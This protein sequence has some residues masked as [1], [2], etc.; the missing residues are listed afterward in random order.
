MQFTPQQLSG[1]AKYSS[2]T[3]VGNWQEEIALEES[4]RENFFYKSS[5][6]NLALRKQEMK[7]SRC[8]EIVSHSYNAD[9]IVRFGDSVVLFHDF[10]GSCLACDPYEDLFQGQEKYLVTGLLDAPLPRARCTFRVERPPQHLRN[11]E[12]DPNDLTLKIGQ[13][14]CLVCNESLL[15]DSN[16]SI[17][18]PSLFL[19][20]TKKNERMATKITNRQL[21]YMTPRCD[22]EAIWTLAKPSLGRLNASERYLSIGSPVTASDVVELVHRQTNMLLSCDPRQKFQTEF[23]VEMECYADRVSTCGK[24]GLLVSEFNG[25]STAHTLSKPDAQVFGWHFVL[26]DNPRSATTSHAL[27]SRATFDNVLRQVQEFILS[28]GV[29]GFWQLRE[30]FFQLEKRT[31]SQGKFDRE[32][33]KDALHAFGIPSSNQYLDM[34]IDR[35]DKQR[36][37][38]I[39]WR[40][41]MDVLRAPLQGVRKRAV[42]DLF[43]KLD[44]RAQ[45]AIAF[46][47]VKAKFH[48]SRHP[49]VAMCGFSEEQA[50]NHFLSFFQDRGGRAMKNASLTSFLDYYADISSCYENDADFMRFLQENWSV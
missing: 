17:L 11:T 42:E 26:S 9:G 50:L 43:L 45:G 5:T 7:I 2:T 12:D 34:L 8:N 35:V 32:D 21:V 1:G 4:K 13:A 29:D 24:L 25:T 15:V 18:K 27:A 23:G 10:S 6:G 48:A 20:S 30:Y 44:P 39:D 36:L 33:L 22:A 46:D 16:S 38:L 40:E 19:C 3:R 31:K 28:R 41:F 14:F 49:L 37:S 47:A